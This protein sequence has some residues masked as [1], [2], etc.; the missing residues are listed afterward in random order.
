[1]LPAIN[2]RLKAFAAMLL[3][4]LLGGY[5]SP[6]AVPWVLAH[7][8][9]IDGANGENIRMLLAVVI[10]GCCPVGVP[11]VLL[12]RLKTKA[13]GRRYKPGTADTCR[14]VMAG[15]VLTRCV[16]V[17][18]RLNIRDWRGP[19]WRFVGPA[20]SFS[21]LAAGAPDGVSGA[22]GSRVPRVHYTAEIASGKA[23]NGREDLGN[24]KPEAIR[25]AAQHGTTPGPF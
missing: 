12:C 16:H 24:A 17:A 4:S 9:G 20:A 3:S 5:G 25:I 19:R 22:H 8:S 23:Y 21:A 1:M 18:A 10:G 7:V 13:E 6:V 11:I 2:D 15:I 14:L